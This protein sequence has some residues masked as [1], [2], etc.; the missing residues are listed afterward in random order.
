[1]A[2]DGGAA[3]AVVTGVGRREGLGFEVCRQL[4]RAGALV[5]LT[6]RDGARA[7]EHAAALASEGLN[8]LGHALD[9]TSEAS[10]A[11]L[12][13]YL[14]QQFGRL[15]ILVNNAAG[16]FDAQAPT[17]TADFD[18]I[19]NALEINLFGPWRMVRVMEPLLKRSARP[20]V[21]NVSSEAASFAAANGMAKRGATLGGYAVS[22]AAQNAMTVKFAAAFAATPILINS[23]CPGWIATYPGTAEQGAR[24][25]A[26]G[27][28][29]VVWAAM[30]PEGGPTG[31]FFRDGQP[32]PW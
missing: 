10:A 23:V 24:P 1:V 7:E 29:G 13:A 21:V 6:A 15:D 25:V 12:A 32:L 28:A 30:L 31:G 11:T 16:V 19:R 17:V 8:V 9:V 18:D 2:E 22:K 4:G 14:H 5:V 3:V 26:D 20:R 27:A